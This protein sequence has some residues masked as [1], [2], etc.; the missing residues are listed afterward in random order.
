MRITQTNDATKGHSCY[1]SRWVINID[2]HPPVGLY[3]GGGEMKLDTWPT[4]AVSRD[5][6]AAAFSVVLGRDVTPH[7]GPGNHAET[8][9]SRDEFKMILQG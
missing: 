6:I 8:P 9:L 4:P 2:G 3:C 5:V 1:W 7:F